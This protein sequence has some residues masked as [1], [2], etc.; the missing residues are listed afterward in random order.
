MEK[1]KCPTCGG[2]SEAVSEQSFICD[3]CGNGFHDIK[4]KTFA[5]QSGKSS[6]K[7]NEKQ[8]EKDSLKGLS[9]K[10]LID[11]LPRHYKITVLEGG[12]I[13]I[14]TPIRSTTAFSMVVMFLIFALV[15]L[16][17]SFIMINPIFSKGGDGVDI[18]AIIG[19]LPFSLLSTIVGIG[20]LIYIFI[21]TTEII[22]DSTQL[23]RTIRPMPTLM[24]DVLIPSEK[25]TQIYCKEAFAYYEH[26]KPVNKFY[27]NI[28][29][30]SDNITIAGEKNPTPIWALETIM[31][32]ALGIEDKI[33][34]GEHR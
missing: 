32:R 6:E 12:G 19:F 14:K 4:E 15:G 24:K 22:I 31:E 28:E 29:H 17:A 30:G 3:F 18:G 23:T 20:S 33:V 25:I 16:V 10:E 27:L 11:K 21:N 13:S 8:S 34:E 2:F 7:Q 5:K 9:Y 1:I 26:G